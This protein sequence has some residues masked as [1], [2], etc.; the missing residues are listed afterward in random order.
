MVR[1]PGSTGSS[2]GSWDR[3]L[4]L[5][6]SLWTGTATERR[7]RDKP[8]V[9]PTSSSTQTP[10]PLLPSSILSHVSSRNRTPP[11]D[12]PSLL[13]AHPTANAP[14]SV[15]NAPS[16]SSPSLPV[17]VRSA[18]E[19]S[20]GEDRW[21]WQGRTSTSGCRYI[22]HLCVVTSSATIAHAIRSRSHLPT[23]PVGDNGCAARGTGST[24]SS[25]TDQ[26]YHY[27]HHHRWVDERL[28]F[29]LPRFVL[30]SFF[31]PRRTHE[32]PSC[33]LSCHVCPHR[34]P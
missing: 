14:G 27:H 31:F 12:L 33:F 19:C 30:I 23:L 10:P 4:E 9:V 17:G 1:K 11:R 29:S 32:R 16:G 34:R 5:E 20:R 7:R 21:W 24:H 22:G 18:E 2:S 8:V 13:S 25:S 26:N 3:C 6:S 15:A 28:R